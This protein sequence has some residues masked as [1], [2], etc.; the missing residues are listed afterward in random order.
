M[1]ALLPQK[2]IRHHEKPQ[3]AQLTD[4]HKAKLDEPTN[5]TRKTDAN[6]HVVDKIIRHIRHGSNI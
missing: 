4:T 6:A 2:D 1:H 5:Q 3:K